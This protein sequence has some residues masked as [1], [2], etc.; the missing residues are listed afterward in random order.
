MII[1]PEFTLR[2]ASSESRACACIY[3]PP[4]FLL[5]RLHKVFLLQQEWKRLKARTMQYFLNELEFLRSQLGLN[6]NGRYGCLGR[7][8]NISG[9]R[10]GH[11]CPKQRFG[12]IASL[13]CPDRREMHICVKRPVDD[14]S[15][16][17][18]LIFFILV[19]QVL[20]PLKI[21]IPQSQIK[22]KM[23]LSLSTN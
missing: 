13:S 17:F 21:S 9:H 3:N 7:E 12:H 16:S 15:L 11:K 22:I 5:S 19:A 8:Y 18:L 23:H 6:W 20:L 1:F 4:S 10:R 2:L 14:Q